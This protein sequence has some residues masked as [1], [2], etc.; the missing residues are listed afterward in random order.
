MDAFAKP[1][2]FLVICD[3]MGVPDEQ[4]D[5]LRQQTAT[6]GR[7]FA[8]QRD[9]AFVEQGN[10][11][12]RVL[13]DSFSALLD[14]RAGRKGDDLLSVLSAEELTDDG[15]RADGPAGGS[16]TRWRDSRGRALSAGAVMREGLRR[17]A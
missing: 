1:L 2:P 7:A 11:A 6:L 16:P 14:E 3:V 13:L 17:A 12:A 9:R 5:W 15:D 4:R 8:N 10:A